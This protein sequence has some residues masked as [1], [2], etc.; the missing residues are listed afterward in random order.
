MRIYYWV[1]ILIALQV[2]SV[3]V[4]V[5]AEG[6][7]DEA[8]VI[9]VVGLAECCPEEAWPEAEEAI[10]AELE[11]LDIPVRIV[12]GVETD[13][14]ARR[15]ELEELAIIENA[16]A[17]I[18]IVRPALSSTESNAD[19]ELWISDRVVGK[20]TYR[21]LKIKDLSASDAVTVVAVRT[22][23]AL[24][25]SLLEL[26]MTKKSAVEVKP[27][28][29]IE[30]LATDT[31]VVGAE[32]ERNITIGAGAGTLFSPGEDG[33]LGGFFVSVGWHPVPFG[34]LMIDVIYAPFS[35]EIKDKIGA[36]TWDLLMFR[37]FARWHILQK[38]VL[39]PYLGVGGGGAVV[40]AD[41]EESIVERIG[42]L[43]ARAGLDLNLGK[44]FRIGAAFDLGAFLPKV[45]LEH[46]K[47]N[48]V[49][50]LGRPLIAI[51]LGLEVRLP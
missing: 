39:T 2:S 19:I 3:V 47:K 42:Y 23:E 14:A 34:G 36:S 1:Y 11:L 22:V 15:A 51:W 38:R 20:T 28:E 30:K 24:R 5:Y 45:E 29:S 33:T 48:L 32:P 21:K 46:S 35:E 18:R 12:A 26:R 27:S 44:R 7:P 40:F 41:G 43:G 13:D 31:E 17:T 8:G 9:V 6:N 25:A 37:G 4:S 50:T 10:R 49:A 16:A